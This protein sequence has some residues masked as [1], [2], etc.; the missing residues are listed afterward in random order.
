LAFAAVP[1]PSS[2]RNTLPKEKIL[3]L[4]D[5]VQH[6]DV[7]LAELDREAIGEGDV[8]E[9]EVD[10]LLLLRERDV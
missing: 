4:G 10:V 9:H 1:S 5:L 6:L 7:P 2:T 8:G 3:L